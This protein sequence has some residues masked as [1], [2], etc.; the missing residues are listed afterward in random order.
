MKVILIRVVEISFIE[1]ILEKKQ[2][3]R[4]LEEKQLGRRNRLC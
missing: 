3:S 4:Y 1:M 2:V